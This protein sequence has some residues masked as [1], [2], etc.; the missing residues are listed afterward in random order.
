MEVS[1]V[2]HC[3]GINAG[4]LATQHLKSTAAPCLKLHCYTGL[5]V[6]QLCFSVDCLCETSITSE[7]VWFYV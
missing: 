3:A 1:L 5:N 2:S 4:E 6:I 7:C